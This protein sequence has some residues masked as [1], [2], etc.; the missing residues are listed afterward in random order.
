MADYYIQFSAKIDR[1]TEA[2]RAWLTERVSLWPGSD[3]REDQDG[4]HGSRPEQDDQ[5]AQV[6]VEECDEEEE[7]DEDEEDDSVGFEWQFVGD[8]LEFWTM[9]GTDD[10]L[11]I[12]QSLVQ[13]FLQTFRPQESWWMLFALTCTKPALNEMT[14]GAVFVTAQGHEYM[15]GFK[16]IGEMIQ[17]REQDFIEAAA[18]AEARRLFAEGTVEWEDSH[19]EEAGV[20]KELGEL[21]F[22]E[23][24]ESQ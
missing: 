23:G 1:L 16:W 10:C 5:V 12:I 4:E 14:G 2:E 19:E 21:E 11:D 6:G 3:I 22:E 8:S 24:A 17:R 7:H 18:I 9:T 20:E 15:D 13:E